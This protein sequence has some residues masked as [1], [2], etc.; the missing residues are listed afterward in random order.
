MQVDQLWNL[1]YQGYRA[2]GQPVAARRGEQNLAAWVQAR[3]NRG[4]QSLIV[5]DGQDVVARIEREGSGERTWWAEDDTHPR[6]IH[7]TACRG[8]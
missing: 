6:E 4:W 5:F 1:S 8:R 7:S 2:D 3:F